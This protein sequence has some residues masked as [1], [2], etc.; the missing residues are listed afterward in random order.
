MNSSFARALVGISLAC[1][2]MCNV[3]FSSR[4]ISAQIKSFPGKVQVERTFGD[5]DAR[6]DLVHRGLVVAL[7]QQHFLRRL[8]DQSL[9][10]LPLPLFERA[11]N[12]RFIH[13]FSFPEACD[14]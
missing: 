2:T 14:R 13:T 12:Y 3:A 11:V 5:T 10:F 6:G 1:S 8:Q 9:A 4:S 7:L